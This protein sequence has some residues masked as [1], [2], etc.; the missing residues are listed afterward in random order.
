[1]AACS[2]EKSGLVG[3][4]Y[5]NMTAKYNAYFIANEKLNEV[6]LEIEDAH[7]NNFNRVLK[8]KSPY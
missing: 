6:L 4:S 3:Y 1:M 8:V 7:K 5:H 2:P